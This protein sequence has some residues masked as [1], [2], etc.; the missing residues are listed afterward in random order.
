MMPSTISFGSLLL[1]I[2]DLEKRVARSIICKKYILPFLYSLRSIATI[3]F[4]SFAI[5]IL[6]VG[7]E[8]VLLNFKQVL[9]PSVISS[10]SE[11]LSLSTSSASLNSIFSLLDEG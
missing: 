2:H 6:T 5:F 11:L 3:S 10:T 8:G 9:H 1:V 4:I 7:R